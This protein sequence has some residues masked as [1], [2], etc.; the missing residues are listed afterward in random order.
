MPESINP[1]D[2]PLLP[3]S[4]EQ[5]MAA[6]WACGRPATRRQIAACLPEHC[7]WADATLL[8]FLA[9]L[10]HRGFVR[11]D[12]QGNK[13]VYTPLVRGR[14]YCARATAVHWAS[15]RASASEITR[16]S[17]SAVTSFRRAALATASRQPRPWALR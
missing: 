15:S 4:E 14:D 7:H 12:R 13:N 1:A 17:T 5:V 8:N 6:L 2:P 9:R 10:E 16:R 11:R 3:A